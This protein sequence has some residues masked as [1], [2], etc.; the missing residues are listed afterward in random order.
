M[1]RGPA[2]S[3]KKKVGK[4]AKK[5]FKLNRKVWIEADMFE[6]AA[7]RSLSSKAMWALLRFL[8]NVLGKRPKLGKESHRR[9]IKRKA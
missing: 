1:A 9:F 2:K 8:Q 3:P 4:V 5:K 6:S 7:F